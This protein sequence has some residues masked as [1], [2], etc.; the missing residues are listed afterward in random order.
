MAVINFINTTVK[1]NN[2][3]L[4]LI[5]GYLYGSSFGLHVSVNFMI[6]CFGPDYGHKIDRNM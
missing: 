2:N 5:T 6:I 3:T 1:H 4:N